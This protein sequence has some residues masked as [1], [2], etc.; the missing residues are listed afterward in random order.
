M[1][2]G[3]WSEIMSPKHP[4]RKES[5]PKRNLRRDSADEYF[6]REYFHRPAVICV[7]EQSRATSGL[8]HMKL[9]RFPAELCRAMYVDIPGWCS[10]LQGLEAGD[11]G[12]SVSRCSERSCAVGGGVQM[13]VRSSLRAQA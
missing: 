6:H 2:A 4:R 12:F 10:R 5:H 1:H 11:S 7:G 13:D 8:L 9:A 3:L